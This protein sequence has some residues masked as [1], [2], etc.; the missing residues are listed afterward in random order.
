MAG[1]RKFLAHIDD[2]EELANTG[3]VNE[4][5]LCTCLIRSIGRAWEIFRRQLSAFATCDAARKARRLT[6][7]KNIVRIV[8]LIPPRR[9]FLFY[10]NKTQDTFTSPS[11]T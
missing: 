11:I 3:G 9:L 7:A 1:K 8:I 6:L 10:I 5:K 2:A 4:Q